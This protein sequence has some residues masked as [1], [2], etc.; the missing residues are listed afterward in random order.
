MMLTWVFI[1]VV[2]VLSSG[3]FTTVVTDNRDETEYFSDILLERFAHGEISR[4][5]YL[6]MQETINET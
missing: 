5:E 6:H 2:L 4:E 1:V 3:L